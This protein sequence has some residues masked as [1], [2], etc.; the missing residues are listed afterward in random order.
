M[1]YRVRARFREQTAGEFR[2]A[3]RE[4]IPRQQPDGQEIVDSMRRAVV[5]ADGA[6]EWSEACYCPVPLQH[7]RSTVYDR[8]FVD[9]TTETLDGYATHDGQPFLAHLDRLAESKR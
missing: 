5:A 6:I 1:Y 2:E 9:L 8:Y 4:S 3:L 7:E